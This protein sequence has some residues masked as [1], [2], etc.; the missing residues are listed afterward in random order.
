[1][2]Q[3]NECSSILL[4]CTTHCLMLG[5]N[6][7]GRDTK[8]TGLRVEVDGHRDMFIELLHLCLR[9]AVPVRSVQALNTDH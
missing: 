4:G 7:S 9:P 2:C 6:L 8:W 3:I 5:S 1:V